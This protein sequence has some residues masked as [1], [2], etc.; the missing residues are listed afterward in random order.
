MKTKV[1]CTSTGCLEYAPERY[2]KMG[3]GIIRIRVLFEGKEYLEGVDLDPVEFYEKLEKLEDP[4]KNL[5]KT[6]MPTRAEI[7][8]H[9]DKAIEEGYDEAIVIAISAYLGGTYNLI[10]MVG[11]EY[12]DRLKVTVID[13]KITCFGEGLLAVKAQ[14]MVNA[15]LPTD[16]IVKEIHWMM[17]HQEFLGVDGKL[18]YLIYNGRLKG[19]KAFFG[20][21]L[22]VCPVVHFSRE[23]E[24]CA[25]CSVRTPKKAL[26]KTCEILKE[27]IGDRDPKD[28][29]LWHT[30]TGTSLIK[31][32][33]EIEGEYGIECNHEPVIVSPVSGCHNGPWLAGYGLLFLRR[34]D[35]PLE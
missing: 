22:S 11:E 19:G 10:R 5:P 35:E 18:D 15:G 28:Y 12:A 30:Y 26:H 21:M 31:T 17:Q 9:F 34:E 14:E 27:I 4:K 3:I 1:F 32:L 16:R 33:E 7:M 2:Q 13:S 20:K 23:G 25:L 8:A 24:C 29:I 6:A